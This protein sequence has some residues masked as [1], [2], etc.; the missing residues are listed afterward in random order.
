MVST[1]TGG[2]SNSIKNRIKTSE[3]VRH[4][5][6]QLALK[7]GIH[8]GSLDEVRRIAGKAEKKSGKTLSQA[9]R[10]MREEAI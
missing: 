4:V 9:V 1:K 8:A 10:R 3:T 5:I 2:M 6:R 7:Y